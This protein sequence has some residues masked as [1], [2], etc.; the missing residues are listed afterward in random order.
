[1]IENRALEDACF[2]LA[3]DNFSSV[4][5]L[6]YALEVTLGMRRMMALDIEKTKI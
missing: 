1:M 3:C 5:C 2:F 4:D 6:G